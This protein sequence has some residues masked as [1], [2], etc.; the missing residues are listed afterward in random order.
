[1]AQT[2]IA[3]IECVF[4]SINT[5]KWNTQSGFPVPANAKTVREMKKS[6]EYVHSKSSNVLNI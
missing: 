4:D 5:K 1:M 3:F 6:N 2:F